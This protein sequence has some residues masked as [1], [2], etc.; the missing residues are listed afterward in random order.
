MVVP[1]AVAVSSFSSAVQVR[2]WFWGV[3]G[4]A[5]LL[6]DGV[7]HPMDAHAQ[8]L[9]AAV[10]GSPLLDRVSFPEDHSLSGGPLGI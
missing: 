2:D 8:K 4:P 9:R 3:A 7:Q 5:F 1:S 6:Y 10:Y